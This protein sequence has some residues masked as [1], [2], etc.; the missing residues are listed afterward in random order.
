M[1]SMYFD[2]NGCFQKTYYSPSHTHTPTLACHI[3]SKTIFFSL[4]HSFGLRGK[5]WEWRT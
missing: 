5:D 4:T 1:I 2:D 3:V